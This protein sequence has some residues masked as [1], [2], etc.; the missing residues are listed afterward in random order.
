M[1]G[2][3]PQDT[4]PYTIKTGDTLYRIAR[5]YNTTVD[6]ILNINPGI[7]PQNLIIGSMICVPT[8]RH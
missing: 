8:L 5:E 7:N 2:N 3:C 6:A 4:I 1:P